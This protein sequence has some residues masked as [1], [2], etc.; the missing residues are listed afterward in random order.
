MAFFVK[1]KG[2]MLGIDQILFNTLVL[3]KLVY[4]AFPI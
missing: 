3:F 1:K 2:D 4:Q